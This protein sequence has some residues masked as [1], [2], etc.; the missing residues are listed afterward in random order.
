MQKAERIERW[1]GKNHPKVGKQGRE[2]KSNVTDNE[3]AIMMTSHGTI[4]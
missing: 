3:A 1:L 4:Q 2:I